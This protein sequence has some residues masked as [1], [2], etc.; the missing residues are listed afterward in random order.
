MLCKYTYFQ[1]N[2]LEKLSICRVI[3]C[4]S[5]MLKMCYLFV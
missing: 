4:D 5:F 2:I 3:S 1:W